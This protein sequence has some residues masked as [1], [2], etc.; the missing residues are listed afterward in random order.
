MKIITSSGCETTSI[1]SDVLT[2]QFYSF[3]VNYT[4]RIM[5]RKPIRYS[6]V[7]VLKIDTILGQKLVFNC[8]DLKGARRVFYEIAHKANILTWSS[9]MNEHVKIGNFKESVLLIK[10]LHGL[11][12]EPHSFIFTSILKCFSAL[13]S[14]EE[15]QMAHGYAIELGLGSHN[16]VG[17]VLVLFYSKLKRIET[18]I[19]LFDKMPRRD[20]IILEHYYKQL[21]IKWIVQK[22]Y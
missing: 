10:H 3:V 9:L 6:A 22:S 12:I 20:I 8:G 7:L 13:L 17:N 14:A 15:G 18:A 19:N 16:V 2:A 11:G 4:L 1:S 5:G 21:Y